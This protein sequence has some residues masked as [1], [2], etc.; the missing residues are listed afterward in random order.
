MLKKILAASAMMLAASQV[1]ALESYNY[2]YV[3][4]MGS[5]ENQEVGNQIIDSKSY[6]IKGQ[7]EMPYIPLVLKA[8]FTN[9]QVDDSEL[10]P[11]QKY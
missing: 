2:S 4:L 3:T 10:A 11:A 1:S 5:F 9:G 6:S 8:G 7:F